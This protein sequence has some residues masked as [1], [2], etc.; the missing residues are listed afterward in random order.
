MAVAYLAVRE[1]D[2]NT[3]LGGV[4]DFV[5]TGKQGTSVEPQKTDEQ[6]GMKWG[7]LAWEQDDNFVLPL[8]ERWIQILPGLTDRAIRQ[9]VFLSEDATTIPKGKFGTSVSVSAA[10]DLYPST[11]A[12]DGVDYKWVKYQFNYEVA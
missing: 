8:H 4:N 1:D 10:T 11:Q 5:F 7:E 6:L 9:R 12:M 2:N 3:P